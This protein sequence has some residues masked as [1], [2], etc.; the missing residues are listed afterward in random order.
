MLVRNLYLKLSVRFVFNI[1]KYITYLYGKK[2]WTLNLKIVVLSI[3][4][5]YVLFFKQ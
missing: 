3:K 2:N 5:V 4:Y 1:L